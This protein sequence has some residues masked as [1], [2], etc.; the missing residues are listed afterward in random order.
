[1]GIKKRVVSS[2]LLSSIILNSSVVVATAT[3]NNVTVGK[4]NGTETI[5]NDKL[6]KDYYDKYTIYENMNV[7]IPGSFLKGTRDNFVNV[8][9]KEAEMFKDNPDP[10]KYGRWYSETH[11]YISPRDPWCAMFV[12]YCLNAVGLYKHSSDGTPSVNSASCQEMANKYKNAGRL[13]SRSSGY[14]P[15]KGDLVLYHNGTRFY[16]VGIFIKEDDN[17]I[18]TVEGNTSST[19]SG[20]QYNGN[21]CYQRKRSKSSS[22]YIGCS[23][24]SPLFEE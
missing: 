24:A 6:L 20:Y 14:K 7:F 2:M 23:F 16:H 12:M 9:L 10:Y 13:Y 1:M 4:F 19:D 18:Y 8:A 15:K 5:E 3:G 11:E 22:T 17:Y 21:C